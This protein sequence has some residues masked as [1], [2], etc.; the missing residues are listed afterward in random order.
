MKWI[1]V[2]KR[3]RIQLGIA[4]LLFLVWL[5]CLPKP[6]F[7]APTATVAYS[8]EGLLIGARI[9]SDGQWRFPAVDSVPY[10][11]EQCILQFEDAYFYKHPGFNPVSMYKALQHNLTKST[12]RGA[13][14][15]TQQVIRLSR[16]Q[17]KRSYLEKLIEIFMATR[18]EARYSKNEILKMH[19]S[20]TPFGGNVVGLET[21]AWRY[22]GLPAAQLSW[23]QSA[24]LAVL[25]NAPSLIFP[26]KNDTSLLN[27]RNR[28]LRKLHATAI[29]DATELELALLEPLPKKP[30]PL[31][32]YAS[33][34]TARIA[35]EYPGQNIKTTID[36]ALQGQLNNIALRH[37]QQLASNQIH[38]LGIVVLEVSSK[39]VLAYIGNTPNKKTEAYY[40]DMVTAQRST[41]STLKPLLFA[42]LLEE[43][44]L[45]PNT[46]VED[47][48]TVINGYEPKNYDNSFSGLVPASSALTRSL[49]IPA[50]R[51][52]QDY[53]LEKFY[54]K[55]EKTTLHSIDKP[56]HHYGLPI[57]LGGAESSLWQ[58][59]STFAGM[60]NTV[61]YYVKNSSQYRK[62]EFQLPHYQKEI[63]PKQGSNQFSPPFLGAGSLYT[64]LQTL[65]KVNRPEGDENWYFF[66][67][68]QALAWKTGTSFGFKDAWAVGTTPKYAIGVWVGNADG[69][70]RPGLTGITAAAPLLFDVLRS[71]P[72]SGWF[73]TPYDDMA[74]V[75]VCTK[76]GYNA[77]PYCED[78]LEEL[79]PTNG[80][81]GA[82]CPYHT[83]ISLDQTGTF[84]VNNACY[85]LAE[86]Q[87]K[88]WFSLPPQLE[89]YYAQKQ[90]NY[91]ALP[92][93]LDGCSALNNDRIAFIYPKKNETILLPKGFDTSP[94]DVVLKLAHQQKD[95]K[96]YWYI[97]HTFV[98]ETEHFH[99]LLVPIT[100]GE[101]TLSVMDEEGNLLSQEITVA[102]ASTD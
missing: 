77:T 97:D 96:V 55:L 20:H 76:S 41:G 83:Q 43:G 5:F 60:A 88:S 24:A 99:E 42:A 29:I 80:K 56:P 34:L 94:E 78:S 13:S 7:T 65:R 44:H 6:L 100:P 16:G 92:P 19:A 17:K 31:P 71:L 26:G 86:M 101:Y 67:D 8:K 32:D 40:V 58:L 33:H 2:L 22:F 69:E 74:T 87:Q 72:K 37:H 4:S 64:T 91:Q 63:I 46:L 38:N 89:Y 52:L 49:N 23:G 47:I 12:R 18:L 53:G 70:G 27:K 84:R 28:L 35:K 90:S 93:F 66:D 10:K 62:N 39:E 51:L 79:V 85:P 45:L 102:T 75:Q 73:S 21:A 25:P 3:H 50:V 36:F 98:G 57:I 14:T 15:L 30:L 59:T 95:A 81:R 48:P 11:Y 1:A 68:S 82:P 54:H 61:N 9:A